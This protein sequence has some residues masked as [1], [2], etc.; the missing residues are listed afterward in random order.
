MRLRML[1]VL[2]VALCASFCASPVMHSGADLFPDQQAQLRVSRGVVIYDID[3][4]PVEGRWFIMKPGSYAVHFSSKQ[5]LKSVNG[6]MAGVIDE[7]ECKVDLELLPGEEVYLKARM[8]IGPSR[9]SGGY[10]KFGFHNEVAVKSSDDT[11]DHLVDTHGCKSSYDCRKA[12]RKN[13]VIKD[14]SS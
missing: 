6:A 13:V 10:T 5:D 2:G 14:C 11:R 4:V 12:N 9:F 3:G 8:K 1:G 7:L